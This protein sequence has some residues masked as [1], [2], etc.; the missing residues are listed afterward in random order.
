MPEHNHDT[1]LNSPDEV[2]EPKLK[3]A[4]ALTS[5]ILAVMKG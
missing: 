4:I 3:F 5:M 1:Q 2:E